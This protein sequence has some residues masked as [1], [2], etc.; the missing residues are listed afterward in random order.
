MLVG[1]KLKS[2]YT[3]LLRSHHSSGSSKSTHRCN[4]FDY[5]SC[6]SDSCTTCE[7]CFLA[8]KACNHVQ[9]FDLDTLHG[10]VRVSPAEAEDWG[11]SYRQK[12][13]YSSQVA[14]LLDVKIL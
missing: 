2:I 13:A 14:S 6:I 9:L 10:F 1:M 4:A 7:R 11:Y 8:Q 3:E 5:T 12:P